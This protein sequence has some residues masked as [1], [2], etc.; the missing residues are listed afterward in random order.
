MRLAAG[1]AVLLSLTACQTT[2]AGPATG[3]YVV[4]AE[5]TPFYEKGPAQGY[6]PDLS[7]TK[8]EEVDLVERSYGFSRVKTSL[9]RVG[10]VAT[11]DIEPAPPPPPSSEPEPSS[12][13]S[14]RSYRSDDQP[15]YTQPDIPLPEAEPTPVTDFRY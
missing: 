3:R 12:S 1:V 7:L 15:V 9:G 5:K 6:G 14:R 13:T 10:Y 2:S 4:S 8:G 11:E